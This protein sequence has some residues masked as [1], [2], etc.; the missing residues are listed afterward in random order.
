[1]VTGVEEFGLFVQ[2][3]ELPAEGL[4]HVSS[5][6]DDYYRFDRA[7]HTLTG[8]RS[9]NSFRLGDACAWPWRGSTSTAASST[10]AVVAPRRR[11]SPAPRHDEER[12]RKAQRQA[13]ATNRT[14]TKKAAARR[15]KAKRSA[16]K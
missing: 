13:N 6:A 8:Y 11:P 7:S 16:R 12:R 2:G 4:M 3:I 15:A 1:M 14:A 5:L 9:G 10:C